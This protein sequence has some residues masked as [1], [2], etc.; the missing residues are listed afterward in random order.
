MNTLTFL[1]FA[2]LHLGSSL[3][4]LPVALAERVREDQRDFLRS[5][6][7]LCET[8]GAVLLFIA[9][10]LFDNPYPAQE[11]AD[12]V[13]DC[14]SGLNDVDVYI[15]PGNHDPLLSDS[16][17]ETTD[18]PEHVHI[19]SENTQRFTNDQKR[20]RIDGAA[21]TSY[22]ADEPLFTLPQEAFDGYRILMWHGDIATSGS[23]YNPLHPASP[24]LSS[25]DYIAMGHVH[26][27]PN[28][29]NLPAYPGFVLGR[30]FDEPGAGGVTL[31]SLS[32]HGVTTRVLPVANTRFE[33]VEADI[34]GAETEEEAMAMIEKTLQDLAGSQEVSSWLSSC[35]LR[36]ILTGGI[37]EDTS[38]NPKILESRLLGL[39]PLQLQ[40]RD[41]TRTALDPVQVANEAGLRGLMAR[42]ILERMRTGEDDAKLLRAFDLL[43]LAERKEALAY[44]D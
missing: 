33:I 11:L 23:R 38:L 41:R 13:A 10:D 19:F 26:N 32:D 35:V 36:L 44:E 2:D 21:F 42:N 12:F 31:A 16:V 25:Y 39:K 4:N 30:G 18:W 9:G 8:H 37:S 6:P 22:Y 34:G 40:L 28:L 43:L 15:T 27:P 17:W 3:G 7:A 29:P 14:L 24:F 5:L 20:V 1:H